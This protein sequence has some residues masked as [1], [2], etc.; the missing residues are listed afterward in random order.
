M[1]NRPFEEIKLANRGLQIGFVGIRNH[2]SLP[3]RKGVKPDFA[4]GLQ[5]QL[6][7][8]EYLEPLHILLPIIDGTTPILGGDGIHGE[9]LLGEIG[10]EP[11]NDS[12]G[13]PRFAVD[14]VHHFL[15]IA[16]AAVEV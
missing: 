14:D 11:V 16:V 2:D 12:Q 1:F 3:A 15:H 8:I 13:N 4:I 6:I 9:V 10:D 5:L 7:T